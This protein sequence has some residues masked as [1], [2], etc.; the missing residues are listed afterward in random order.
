MLS[1]SKDE[2]SEILKGNNI[3]V[4]NEHWFSKR[5]QKIRFFLSSFWDIIYLT[6][7][8][9]LNP[10]SKYEALNA[11]N[12]CDLIVDLSGDSITEDYG[13]I[14]LMF[15]LYRIFLGLVARKKIILLSQTIGPFKSH[16]SKILVR[17]ILDRVDR[18]VLREEKSFRY[19]KEMG[20]KN[21]NID[22]T[23]DIGFLLEPDDITANL[24][25]SQKNIVVDNYQAIGF[26]PSSIIFKWF[27][28]GLPENAK[29]KLYIKSMA[30]FLDGV[31]E[32]Y[33][34]KVVLIP[35]VVLCYDNDLVIC[36]EIMKYI[37][38]KN[39]AYLIDRYYNASVLKAIM[40]RLKFVISF[41]MHA[42]IGALSM[43]V[44][45]ICWAYSEKFHGIIG[46]K[47]GLRE[48]VIDVRGHD[49]NYA[50]GMLNNAVAKILQRFDAI[51]NMISRNMLISKKE[52][53]KNIEIV[54][55]ELDKC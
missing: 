40:A 18:I 41:R 27:K 15:V 20:I 16:I 3:I 29:R 5:K 46:E 39:S 9:W 33:N 49:M 12:N 43:D 28:G 19:L 7:G 55:R 36:K 24:V 35:H 44:P 48:Y 23:S 21:K 6:F 38:N 32:K 52:A 50:I 53:S 26:S 10:K 45:A 51:K 47:L 37:K 30:A 22:I 4:L 11:Y 17:Y 13:R 42:A 8:R 14:S 34:F 2:D 54:L 1:I 31:I 25:L